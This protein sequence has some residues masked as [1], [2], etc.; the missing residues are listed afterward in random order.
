[1]TLNYEQACAF[2]YREARY[3]DD[4]DW[5]NWL[6]LYAP[7]ATFWMPAW[8]D[9]GELTQDP[10]TEISLIWYGR[11]AGLEDRVPQIFFD[12]PML[13]RMAVRNALKDNLGK[14]LGGFITSGMSEFM[15]IDVSAR[16]GLGNL[17]PGTAM[18]KPSTTD[19]TGELLSAIGGVP[20][21]VIE[22]MLQATGMLAEGNFSG[23]LKTAAPKAVQDVAKGIEMAATGE[24]RD[25]SGK[26]V[27][28]VGA[29]DAFCQSMGFNP[30]V[31]ADAGRKAWDVTEYLGYIKKTE[32][33]IVGRWARGIADNDMEAVRAAQQELSDWN[34]SN[35]E[36][37]IGISRQQIRQR[38]QQLS[39]E[40]AGRIEKTAPKELRSR[41]RE[42]VEED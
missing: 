5:D 25:R 39:M 3:L 40:R 13:S 38:V 2:L 28:D 21:G 10:Q 9:D 1:M 12:K 33:E 7:D 29:M 26:K 32:S 37:P 27:V 4:K 31:K 11:R 24:A 19:K 23:A 41:V 35:P 18:L 22:S 6:E 20:G 42:M 8:D 14:E 36:S 16:M 17:I 30:S 34:M 15:P